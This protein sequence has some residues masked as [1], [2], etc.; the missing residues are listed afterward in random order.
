M[1]GLVMKLIL[2]F[3]CFSMFDVT[4]SSFA[5]VIGYLALERQTE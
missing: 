1:S 5:H 4:L 2:L 3:V